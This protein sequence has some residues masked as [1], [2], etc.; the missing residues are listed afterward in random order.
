[1]RMMTFALLLL[2]AVLALPPHQATA[3]PPEGAS[4][5]MVLDQVADGLR[6]YRAEKDAGKRSLLMD[7]LAAT[8]D[9]R[10]AVVLGELM[11]DEK[12]GDG[13]ETTLGIFFACRPHSSVQCHTFTSQQVRLWWH[14]NE[15]DLRRRAAQL[16]R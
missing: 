6:N 1:M 5:K 16:P 13:A 3:G 11:R 7:R 8:G 15:A 4:G 12:E 9:P 10:V 2:L 14:A